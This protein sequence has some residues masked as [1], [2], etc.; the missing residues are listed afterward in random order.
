MTWTS[1]CNLPQQIKNCFL[2]LATMF[3]K[4][5][6]SA[7]VSPYFRL[8]TVLK[9]ELTICVTVVVFDSYKYQMDLCAEPRLSIRTAGRLSFRTKTL[10]LDIACKLFNQICSYLPCLQSSVTS[11]ILYHFHWHG[12]CLLVTKS[13]QIKTYWLCFFTHFPSDQG[14][15]WCGKIAF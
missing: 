7:E 4:I 1:C 2:S 5:L 6:P 9:W 10:T 11:T 12:P 14:E 15:I 13:V 8:V 3:T